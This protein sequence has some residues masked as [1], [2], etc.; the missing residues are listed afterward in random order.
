MNLGVILSI[1]DLLFGTLFKAPS[2]ASLT[3]GFGREE[4]VSADTI[5]YAYIT[6]FKEAAA[7][8]LRPLKR[9]VHLTNV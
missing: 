6:S 8:I 2:Q 1:W 9:K 3:F 4:Y 5:K 7:V